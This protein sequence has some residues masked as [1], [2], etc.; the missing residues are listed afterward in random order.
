MTLEKFKTLL[1]TAGLPVAYLSFPE[2][3]V[4]NLPFLCFISPGETNF[5]ADGKVYFKSTKI[6]VELYLKSRSEEIEGRVENA[7]SSFFYTKDA[8]YL[9]DEKCWEVVY[10]L[11]V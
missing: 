9:D 4:P 8:E 2:E 1:E 5:A 6:V 10:E 7:L 3:E 11:E